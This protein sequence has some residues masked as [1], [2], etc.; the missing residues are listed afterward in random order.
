MWRCVLFASVDLHFSNVARFGPM[1]TNWV[2]VNGLSVSDDGFISGV[3]CGIF[4][5]RTYIFLFI[6]VISIVDSSLTYLR[7]R[8]CL[9]GCNG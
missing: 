1:A 3:S 5:L 4:R 7:V 9:L 6:S 2:N 8:D